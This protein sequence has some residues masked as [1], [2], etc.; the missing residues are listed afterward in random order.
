[1]ILAIERQDVEGV[2]LD[3]L[4]MSARVQGVEGGNAVDPLPGSA[5][6]IA[7]DDSSEAAHPR[8]FASQ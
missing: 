3:L 6:N 1:M 5:G 7:S 8:N 4:V 2:Q